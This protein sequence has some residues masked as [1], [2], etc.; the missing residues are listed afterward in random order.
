MT[1]TNNPHYSC[2]TSKTNPYLDIIAFKPAATAIAKQM[3]IT[4]FFDRASYVTNS[5]PY[6]VSCGDGKP[7]P[8][9]TK[10]INEVAAYPS[11]YKCTKQELETAYKITFR[12][13]N[14]VS[15]K[16]AN[17]KTIYDDIF[18]KGAVLLNEKF[19]EDVTNGKLNIS[20]FIDGMKTMGNDL[21]KYLGII[22]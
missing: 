16:Y 5:V 15:V 21:N 2:V 19:F 6:I 11:K 17:S 22:V 14:A 9:Y 18:Q 10:A 8:I 4:F 1:I 7:S 3:Q 13:I 12:V 20:Y